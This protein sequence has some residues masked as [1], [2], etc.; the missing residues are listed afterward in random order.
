MTVFG[1]NDVLDKVVVLVENSL[2]SSRNQG[3][4]NR[5]E[6]EVKY[7]YEAFSRLSQVSKTEFTF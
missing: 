5:Q 4:R 2:R 1:L 7:Y 6:Q 3:C